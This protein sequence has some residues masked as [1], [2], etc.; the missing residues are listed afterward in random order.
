MIGISF[1]RC[2]L[3]RTKNGFV[4]KEVVFKNSIAQ[5][6][7]LEYGIKMRYKGIIVLIFIICI[8]FSISSVCASDINESVIDSSDDTQIGL[9]EVDDLKS[10]ENNQILSV[11]EDSFYVLNELI[12]GNNNDT[13]YLDKSYTFDHSFDLTQ[14]DF[15]SAVFK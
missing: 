10:N 5:K 1:K 3:K 12:N 4:L 11:S 14:P 13:I 9:I 15:N 2:D 8:L 7:R 6:Y